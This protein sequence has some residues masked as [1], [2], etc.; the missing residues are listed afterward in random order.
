MK[1]DPKEVR[2]GAVWMSG[3]GRAF[4]AAG[5]AT[6]KALKHEHAAGR[7]EAGE[8]GGIARSRSC[9]GLEAK[10]KILEF[11]QHK[12]SSQWRILSRKATII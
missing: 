2:K 12:M 8:I 11:S 4:Q 1:S 9:K 3:G 6:A 7:P 5:K 10:V